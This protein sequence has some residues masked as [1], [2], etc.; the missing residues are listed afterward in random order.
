MDEMEKDIALKSQRNALI[1]VILTLFIW[2]MYESYKVYTFHTSINL[3][4]C[5]VLVTTTLVQTFSQLILQRRA[6]QGDEEY[7]TLTP[8]FKFLIIAIV[9]G[10][11]I[12]SLGAW[13]LI[14]RS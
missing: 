11:I 9:T 7:G 14:S 6:V 8:L 13:L 5:F 4:P 3:A 1:Y 2:T 10:G 12:A